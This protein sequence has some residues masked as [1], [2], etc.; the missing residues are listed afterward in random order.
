MF[1]DDLPSTAKPAAKPLDG[2]SV[3]ELEEYI[4]QLEAEIVRVREVLERKRR[5]RGS[6][7]ALF[8]R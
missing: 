8:K 4:A 7:D 2:L 1:D 6:A 5:H 3:E